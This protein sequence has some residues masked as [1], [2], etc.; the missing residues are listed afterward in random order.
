MWFYWA[1]HIQSWTKNMNKNISEVVSEL[2][3]NAFYQEMLDF[4][5]ESFEEIEILMKAF[6]WNYASRILQA[7]LIAAKT[8][9]LYP[10]F[11]TSFKCGTDS[12]AIEYFKKIMD[13]YNKPY[14]FFEPMNMVQVPDMK[15]G[16][17]PE[18]GH[19]GII[20]QGKVK[21]LN[22]GDSCSRSWL[23]MSREKFLSELG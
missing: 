6:H 1:G 2:N 11:I 18:Y 20:M 23:I 4:S 8:E 19:P 13:A 3:I 15:L 12:F 16:L 22:A 17:K 9:K 5:G 10:V 21:N 14:L 7:A